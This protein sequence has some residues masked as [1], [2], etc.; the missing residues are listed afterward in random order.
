MTSPT[1]PV[2]RYHG[3]KWR[4]APWIIRHFPPHRT[5]VEPFGGAGSVLMRKPRSYSEVYNDQWGDVVN[6]F[7]VLRD[8]A[9]AARLAA[10]LHLTPFARA[11]FE[12]PWPEEVDQV[13][14][15]RRTIFRSLAGFGSASTNGKYSTGFR[16]NSNRSHTT[17]AHD[18]ANYPA[19][20][21]AFTERFR[22]VVIE[23][24]P[25]LRV[26]EQHDGPE[27][28]IYCD[29]PYPLSTRNVARGNAR[30]ACEM[31]DSD[32]RELAARLHQV[33]G[34][35]VISGYPCELYD[36]ELY[37]DWERITKVALAD[38]ARRRTE[39]LWLNPACSR[40]LADRKGAA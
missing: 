18:W 16:S 4:L 6:V 25:A 22:G 29:P 34:M 23:Q 14:R 39:V 35:V 26:I 7:R 37:P 40:A 27:V 3:G 38:G 12:A 20:V 21:P 10:L 32:H 24:R 2:L 33:E 19:H 5:Y 1:R 13:E 8:E 9:S 30:Y 31:T 11:E 28:L 17:P 36:R 15:A